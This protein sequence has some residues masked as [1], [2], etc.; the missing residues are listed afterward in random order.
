MIKQR[1]HQ[2]RYADWPKLCNEQSMIFTL[3]LGDHLGPEQ[4]LG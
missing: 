2:I 3:K 4:I 1:V